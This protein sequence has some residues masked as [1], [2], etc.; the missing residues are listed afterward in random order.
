MLS[1]LE[2]RKISMDGSIFNPII[3]IS[4]ITTILEESNL[5]KVDVKCRNILSQLLIYKVQG[6]EMDK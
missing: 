6:Q 5:Y 2:F 1:L 4:Q 3:I